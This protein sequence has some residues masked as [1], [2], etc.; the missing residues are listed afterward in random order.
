MKV[1]V[2]QGLLNSHSYT[3]YR[4]IVTDLLSQGKVSGHQQSADLVHYTELNEVRMNRLD[5]KMEITE[6]VVQ[7]LLQLKKQYI[8]LVLAE[9]WCG[10][11]AQLL[12]IINKMANFS[13]HIDLKIAFRD[14]HESL[15]NMFLTNG[16]KAI[17][18][19]IV[20]DKEA[21]KVLGN[22]GARPK[23]A[24]QLI[25][26]YKQQY[27]VVDETAKTELQLWYLHDKGI[28]TQNEIADLM[29]HCEQLNLQ[30]P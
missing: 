28:S 22:W 30:T 2:A 14:E 4:A 1:A 27:G 11:A 25:K 7:K 9:G 26:S 8:W 15:M 18:K 3:K 6:E 10:D 20:L 29:L 21:E 12:P 23:G 24:D 17:P 13:Q 5:K 19:L 16:N